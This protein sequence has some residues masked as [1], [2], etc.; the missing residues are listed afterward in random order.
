MSA[1]ENKIHISAGLILMITTLLSCTDAPQTGDDFVKKKFKNSES[2]YNQLTDSIK[3]YSGANLSEF[4]AEYLY[5]WRLDSMMCINSKQD[6]LVAAILTSVGVF[7]NEVNDDATKI[8]GK[9]INGNWYFFKGSTLVIPRSYYGKTGSDP[10]TFHEL[11]QIARKEMLESALIKNDEGEY[12]V[13]DK[14]V[15][16]HFTD[17]GWGKFDNT[18]QYDSVH[19]FH[20]MDKWKHKIDTIEYKPLKKKGDNLTL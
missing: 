17:L 8:L 18:A 10:L 14:W 3:S 15:E 19:W 2:I 9:K 5:D 11:S 12:V 1:R 6:R 4:S 13:D 16:A 20:I 7:N